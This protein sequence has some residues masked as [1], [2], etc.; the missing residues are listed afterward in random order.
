[1]IIRRVSRS[2]VIAPLVAP[3]G[4]AAAFVALGAAQSPEAPGDTLVAG[5]KSTYAGIG[6]GCG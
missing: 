2:F 5:F 4:L 6:V 3:L 1:M